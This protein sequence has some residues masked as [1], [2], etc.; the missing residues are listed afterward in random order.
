[1]SNNRPKFN[2][3]NKFTKARQ[4]ESK[5]ITPS[6]RLDQIRELSAFKTSEASKKISN[7]V[8]IKKALSNSLIGLI[9]IQLMP[10]GIGRAGELF[11]LNPSGTGDREYNG[12]MTRGYWFTS[13]TNFTLTGA[14]VWAPTGFTKTWFTLLK[15]DAA[16]PSWPTTNTNYTTLFTGEETG[17]TTHTFSN[18]ISVTSGDVIGV[19]GLYQKS[20]GTKGIGYYGGTAHPS[21]GG[22]STEVKRF[23][24]QGLLNATSFTGNVWQEPGYWSNRGKIVLQESTG[25]TGTQAISNLTSNTCAGGTIT[26]GSSGTFNSSIDVGTGCT[27]DSTSKSGVLTGVYS[28]SGNLTYKESLSAGKTILNSINTYTGSSTVKDKAHLKIEGSI[29]TSSGLTVEAGGT[30]SGSSFEVTNKTPTTTFTGGTF[31]AEGSNT[32]AKSFVS[33]S[34]GAIIDNK[35]YSPTLSGVFSGS[36]GLTFSNSGSGGSTTLSGINT[37]TGATAV[38]DDVH[39]KVNGSIA[40]SSSLSVAADGIIS[41]IGYYPTTNLTTGAKISPGNSIGTQNFTNLNLNGGSLDIEIQGPQ[42]DKISVTGNVT[43]FT[44][45]ANIIPYGGGTLWPNFNYSIINAPNSSDFSLTNS[46]TLNPTGVTSV[47]L[48]RGATLTQENDGDPKTFDIKYEPKNGSG[49]TASALENLGKSSSGAEIFD[50]AFNSLATQAENNTNNTGSIIGNTGFTTGQIAAAGISEDFF[51]SLNN[52]LNLTNDND[53]INAI[54]SMSPESYSAFQSVGLETIKDR[55]DLLV[56]NAGNCTRRG[57]ILNAKDNDYIRNPLCFFTLNSN[58]IQDINGEKGRSSYQSNRFSTHYGLEYLRSKN[59]TIGAAFGHGKSNLYKMSMNNSSV[60]SNVKGGAIYA[61]NKLPIG[62]QPSYPGRTKV[63]GI[64]GY[65][66]FD[67]DG[68]RAAPPSNLWAD[69]TNFS[70]QYEADGLTAALQIDHKFTKGSKDVYVKPLIGIAYSYYDQQGFTESSSN[71]LNLKINSSNEKSLLATFAIEVGSIKKASEKRKIT[72]KIRI[73]LET[74]IISK[75]AN[76]TVF[77][78]SS[79]EEASGLGSFRTKGQ[80]RGRDTA[81]VDGEVQVK[82]N[83]FTTL[84]T[85]ASYTA[86]ERGSDY[87]FGGG[88]RIKF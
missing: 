11:H 62:L 66:H 86:F 45:T 32:Y 25:I 36:G 16:P 40:S 31:E 77:L 85:D 74:E 37:Y 15:L 28:G 48:N 65:N 21:I 76:R 7:F 5:G 53:L 67:I 64:I 3:G 82:I 83:N 1:M 20:N 78:D 29:A 63:I 52:L 12:N 24:H 60:S 80:A 73:G 43:N 59:L 39:L 19:L 35:A 75:D 72:S 56:S 69:P 23:G 9:A 33:G 38:E 51:T 54:N 27:I 55:R 84:Y 50:I 61:V 44:G 70:A 41:G 10:I 57:I 30:I 22:V 71:P 14:E 17:S 46:L 81:F 18:S 47:I 42:N 13:P 58:T 26:F 88:I 87:S 6:S 2:K 8:Y 49:V 79:F 34:G 68:T 4:Y